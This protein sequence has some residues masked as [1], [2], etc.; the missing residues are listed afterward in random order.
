MVFILRAENPLLYQ[1]SSAS[2]LMAA[3]L[4]VVWPIENGCDIGGYEEVPIDEY[5]AAPIVLMF[6]LGY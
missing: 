3:M 6:A 2:C 5:R 1:S 4:G